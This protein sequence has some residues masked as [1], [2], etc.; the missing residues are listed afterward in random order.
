MTT[1]CAT[2]SAQWPAR[3]FAQSM[4]SAPLAVEQHVLGVEIEVDDRAARSDR[5]KPL[6][7]GDAVQPPMK[8]GEEARVVDER[9]RL[10]REVDAHR[11]PGRALEHEIRAVDA[12]DLG[13]G[14]AALA[15]VAHDSDLAGGNV[16]AAVATQD[17]SRIERVHVRVAAARYR[18]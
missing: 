7:R 10:S 18:L 3:A 16:S 5:G 1:V 4:T 11:G 12:H 17:G 2:S 8:V 6:G 14:I 9:P 15:Y 13:R